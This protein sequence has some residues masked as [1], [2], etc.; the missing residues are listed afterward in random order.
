MDGVIL[1]PRAISI[2]LRSHLATIITA[3]TLLL[4][5]HS[6][7]VSI[8]PLTNWGEAQHEL[9]VRTYVRT[10][11]FTDTRHRIRITKQ[12]IGKANEAFN[13]SSEA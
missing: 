3:I 6:S 9:P 11:A 13:C 10:R 2:E 12:G 4:Y 5:N 8:P 7:P 1:R